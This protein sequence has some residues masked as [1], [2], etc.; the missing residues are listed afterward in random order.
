MKFRDVASID[1]PKPPP[2]VSPCLAHLP[3]SYVE[4]KFHKDLR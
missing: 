1:A 2:K 3:P 4:F